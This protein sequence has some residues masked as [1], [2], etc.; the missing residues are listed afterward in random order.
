MS[1]ALTDDE[2]A[3]AQAM[4]Q[5]VTRRFVG[6][7]VVTHTTMGYMRS[8]LQ[9]LSREREAQD[10]RFPPGWEWEVKMVTRI[11]D[12]YEPT[13]SGGRVWVGTKEVPT[14]DVLTRPIQIN[15]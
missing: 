3:H 4:L 13:A 11:V 12:V 2:L 5:E 14:G 9:A 7:E 10:P 8:M 1:R 6:R 15:G